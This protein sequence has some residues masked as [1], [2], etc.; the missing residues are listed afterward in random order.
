MSKANRKGRSSNVGPFVQLPHFLL[1]SP[2]WRSLTAQEQAAYVAI[3]Q[4][5]NGSN[6][7]RLAVSVR[8]VAERANVNKDTAG[9]CLATLQ[10]KGFVECASPGGFSRKVR[11]AAEWR[12]TLYRCDRT[13]APPL[14]AFMRWRPENAEH[15]PLVSDNRSPRFGQSEEKRA[16]TVPPFRTVGAI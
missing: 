8:Q 7:G 12:L 6:N 10:A 1:E 5:Y 16:A 13:Q 3:A 9:R 2:A 14:K 15:G 11:H 4:V